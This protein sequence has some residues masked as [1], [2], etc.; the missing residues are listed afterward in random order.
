[1]KKNQKSSGL[2]FSNDFDALDLEFLERALD[3]ARSTFREKH[4]L[5]DDES[6]EELETALRR[7]LIEIARSNGVTDP[8]ILRDILLPG[9]SDSVVDQPKSLSTTGKNSNE[10]RAAS[11][12]S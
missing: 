7:D 8:D 12:A 1:V 6:D 5:V 11:N 2:E 10:R 9:L 3:S 4:E